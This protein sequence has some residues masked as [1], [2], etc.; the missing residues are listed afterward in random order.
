[1]SWWNLIYN[2]GDGCERSANDEGKRGKVSH[3]FFLISILPMA[4]KRDASITNT[5]TN[6][7][8]TEI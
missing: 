7:L 8:Q 5:N 4:I 3:S 2:T 6:T 1:L